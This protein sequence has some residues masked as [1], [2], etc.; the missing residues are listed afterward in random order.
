MHPN[1]HFRKETTE[2]NITFARDRAFGTLA[3]NADDGPLLSHIPFVL[4]E[5]ANELEFHLVRSNPILKLIDPECAAVLAVSGPD[6]YIS[7]DWYGIDDQVP[8]WNYIAVHIRGVI[9]ILPQDDLSAI[10]SRLSNHMEQR[11]SPKKPWTSDKMTPEVYQKMLR[12]IVPVKM[13]IS[14]ID[15]TWKLSQNKPDQV[16]HSALEHVATSG[17]GSEVEMVSDLMAGL[18]NKAE[19]D[20]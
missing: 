7:P 11:L 1:P 19:R 15:G 9:S 3:I 2:R 18:D 8:T 12:Q 5:D 10:L 20:T 17:I 6:S 13:R 14:S 4:S 16:R